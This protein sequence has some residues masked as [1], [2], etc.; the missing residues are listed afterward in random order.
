[1]ES[2]ITMYGREIPIEVPNRPEKRKYKKRKGAKAKAP[3][4]P[5]GDK[6]MRSPND[7]GNTIT[8]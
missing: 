4:A 3:S 7:G 6:M 1:M 5:R 2:K 8:K